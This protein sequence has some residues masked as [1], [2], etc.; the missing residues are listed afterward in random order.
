VVK[1]LRFA[2]AATD[3][4]ISEVTR[5]AN[6]Q[7]RLIASLPPGSRERDAAVTLLSD[8]NRSIEAWRNQRT[9]IFDQILE[10]GKPLSGQE[11]REAVQ[12]RLLSDA[13]RWRLKAEELRTVASGMIEPSAIA[14]MKRL[15]DDYKLL[16]DRAEA[17]AE[18]EPVTTEGSA[19]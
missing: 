4:Q 2:L 13:H 10:A 1:K 14:H 8:L 15:A 17:R 16:A 9:R 19:V 12:R 6:Q 11:L 3:R 5:S 18:R 7:V